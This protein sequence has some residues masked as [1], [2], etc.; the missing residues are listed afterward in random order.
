MGLFHNPFLWAAIGLSLLLQ[1]LVV[2]VSWLN[3][4]FDTQPL[5]AKDWL[6]CVAIASSVLW[7]DE[8]KKLVLKW[9]KRGT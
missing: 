6:Y 2:S 3:V 8:L 9:R 7:A 5:P 4:A 1:L